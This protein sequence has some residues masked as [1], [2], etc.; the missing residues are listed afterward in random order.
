MSETTLFVLLSNKQ[1]KYLVAFIVLVSLPIQLRLYAQHIVKSS[2]ELISLL[3]EDKNQGVILLDGDLF[4]IA[5]IE[6]KAGGKIIPYPG[7]KPSLIGFHQKVTRDNRPED[8]N[9]YWLVP[10]KSYGS[11]QIVFLD[12][13]LD[14][15]PYSCSLNGMNGFEI[16]EEQIKVIKKEERLI[17]VPIPHDFDYMKNRDK[18]F[19]KNFSIKLSYWFV[20]M[21]LRQIYSDG[22]YI[23]G[24]VDSQYNFNLLSVR[25]Y[26]N[27]RIDFF[28]LPK[29]D[30][31]IYLDGND[32]LHV[33]SKYETVH[34]C[35]TPPIF[36]LTGDRP[37]TFDGVVFTGTNND[38][39]EIQG[40]NKHFNN[41]VI[42]NCGKGIVASDGT[43]SNCTIKN[44]LFEN[45]LNNCAISFSGINDAIIESNTIRHTGTLVKGGS[46]ITVSG[47]NFLVRDNN[48]SD[49][50]YIGISVGNT[51]EY[52][53]GTNNGVIIENVVDNLANYGIANKQLDDGGG[54]YVLTHTDG[55]EISNNIIR[56][57]G[58]DNA[59]MHGIYLDDGAYNVNVC[60]NLVY[61][62]NTNSKAIYSR[63]V[64]DCERSCMN[65]VFVGNI[66][67]G[68]CVIAGNTNGYGNK[69]L[70]KN[71]YLTGTIDN[72]GDSFVTLI[73]NR[74]IETE[75]QK[76]G[77]IK[78]KKKCGLKKRKYSRSIRKLIRF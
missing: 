38:V 62:I 78:F 70:I 57:I 4:H 68:N 60:N 39:I 36:K 19:F 43:Y 23:Y 53:P 10:I 73:N 18:S 28:N 29:E 13:K 69:T 49:F 54:I 2:G 51:R 40:S 16:K 3:S 37:I 30:G 31:G 14:A 75:I 15:I 1:T 5:G 35:T 66:C 24:I 8:A 41:C 32:I 12:E 48:I 58:Y 42:R 65:N 33:P 55:V 45:L 63:F 61:N 76:N 17:A 47:L 22:I 46:V 34:V 44:C 7:R 6:V 74:V 72:N 20:G 77:M 9:G 71:N 21:E 27:V 50:S 59:W 52:K 56:N 67:V 25:P 64:D 26:A 11:T